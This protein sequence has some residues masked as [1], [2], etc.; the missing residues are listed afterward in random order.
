MF[1]QVHCATPNGVPRVDSHSRRRPKQDAA[2]KACI[3]LHNAGRLEEEDI[4]GCQ[5]YMQQ[6]Q[7]NLNQNANFKSQL[8]EY[9]ARK[10]LPH[11]E[12]CTNKDPTS[13][14]F[15]CSVKVCAGCADQLFKSRDSHPKKKQAEE[16]AAEW[17]LKALQA[18]SA[19][20]SSVAAQ[21]SQQNS[22]CTVSTSVGKK[23][24]HP[25]P[26]TKQCAPRVRLQ[27][28]EEAVGITVIVCD[29]IVPRL[30][31]LE[32]TLLGSSQDGSIPERLTELEAMMGL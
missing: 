18:E 3:L 20:S 32:K 5:H 24:A 28:L 4:H 29:A 7:S 8:F 12:F 31:A 17:A 25:E 10:H 26:M 13:S 19:E 27:Q 16:D 6:L 30:N 1:I 22:T 2:Y 11:P 9:L 23:R 15:W 21:H 14:R